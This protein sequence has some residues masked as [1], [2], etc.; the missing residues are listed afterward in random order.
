MFFYLYGLYKSNEYVIKIK[1]LKR[2]TQN[3]SL[4]FKTSLA[5]SVEY[6]RRDIYTQKLMILFCRGRI[7]PPRVIL[8]H[9]RETCPRPDR[10]A[11]IYPWQARL[12]SWKRGTPILPRFYINHWGRMQYAPTSWFW[13]LASVFFF[14]NYIL[15]TRYYILFYNFN[16]IINFPALLVKYF[17]YFLS[18]FNVIR[19]IVY[20]LLSWIHIT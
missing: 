1:N 3:H 8:C 16:K 18:F 20:Y 4:K 5:F 10:G 9:S 2:K 12:P 17:L 14:L 15:Y 11:G 19:N 13:I 7:H 6:N